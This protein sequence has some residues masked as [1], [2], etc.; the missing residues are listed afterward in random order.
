MSKT[1]KNNKVKK[2]SATKEIAK[3][4]ATDL[5]NEVTPYK[6]GFVVAA[7]ITVVMIM[8][9]AGTGFYVKDPVMAIVAISVALFMSYF[10]IISQL[11]ELMKEN[12]KLRS[13]L[14]NE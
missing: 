8:I 7:V 12:R 1:R 3:M 13:E 11:L 4:A 2:P 10:I 6:T 14:E 9:F 5:K